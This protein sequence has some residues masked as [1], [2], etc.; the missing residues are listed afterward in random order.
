[1]KRL[2]HTCTAIL[3]AATLY[4]VCAIGSAFWSGRV[5]EILGGR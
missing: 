1:M 4:F 3:I 5:A 2:N